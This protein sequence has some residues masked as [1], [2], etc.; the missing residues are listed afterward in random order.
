[1]E[2]DEILFVTKTDCTGK[3]LITG[4]QMCCITFR[5]IFSLKLIQEIE[6]LKIKRPRIRKEP[7]PGNFVRA[8]G[9][10][11]VSVGVG[12]QPMSPSDTN[13]TFTSNKPSAITWGANKETVISPKQ[14]NH[15]NNNSN[16]INNNEFPKLY[17][18][19]SSSKITANNLNTL[20][21][22]Q[23]SSA[24]RS[25][26]FTFRQSGIS[27]NHN[28]NSNALLNSSR[29]SISASLQKQRRS[30][31]LA[32]QSRSAYTPR[33]SL[34]PPPGSNANTNRSSHLHAG[35]GGAARISTHFHGRF[36]SVDGAAI[37]SASR[38]ID[39]SLDSD[40]LFMTVAALD[41]ES[42]KAMLFLYPLPNLR[43]IHHFERF[44]HVANKV[45]R[46]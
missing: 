18:K 13:S 38:I 15:T 27:N 24:W 17:Q 35:G 5:D 29:P 20:T 39:F 23:H 3:I 16:N 9:G 6:V 4:G 40:N 31:L 36:S 12:Q 43:H 25:Q 37:L 21:P 10:G 7:R 45:L 41:I 34:Q 32:R 22:H 19:N 2:L 11:G 8:A 33:R 44:A 26:R 42:S 30:R 1:M 46:F 14:S 28:N